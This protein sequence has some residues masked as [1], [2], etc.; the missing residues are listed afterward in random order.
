GL[1]GAVGPHETDDLARCDVEVDAVDGGDAA[2]GLAQAASGE[3]RPGLPRVDEAGE[4]ERAER[5]IAVAVGP[6]AGGFDLVA[7]A[8]EEHRPHEVA[9]LDDLP[10][11][12]RE[13]RLAL[14]QEH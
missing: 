6:V 4:V 2:E 14:L 9:A 7:G 3:R 10:G 12:A 8:G 5:R 13:A 11:R 1:P